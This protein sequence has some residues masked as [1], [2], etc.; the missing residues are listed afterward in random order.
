MTVVITLI[1]Y[2]IERL[3]GAGEV[4]IKKSHADSS[5]RII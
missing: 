5:V 4:R 2:K 3:K 1:I